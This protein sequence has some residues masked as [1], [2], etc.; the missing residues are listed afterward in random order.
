MSVIRG[1]SYYQIVEGPTWTLAESNAAKHGGHLTSIQ[2][3]TE[4]AFL[5]INFVAKEGDYLTNQGNH[6]WIGAS[7]SGSEGQ[8]RWSDGSQ[9][10]YSNWLP[11][12]PDNALGGENYGSLQYKSDGYWNDARDNY[13]QEQIA[14]S[15]INGI[16]E[17]PL[18]LSITHI[19]TPKEGAEIFTTSINL[20]AGTQ[21]S[22]NLAEGAKVYWKVTGITEDDLHSGALM[23]SGYISNGSLSIQ[24]SLRVDAD[25][26]EKM[27][28]SVFSDAS[29]TQQIGNASSADI[30]ESNSLNQ[31]L[32]IRG[33][34]IYRVVDGPTWRSAEEN[35]TKLGGHLFTVNT[36]AE[37]SWLGNEFSDIKYEYPGDDAPWA[38]NEFSINHFWSGGQLIGG[39]W[40]WVSG[41]TFNDNLSSLYLNNY[42]SDPASDKLLGIFN[43]PN[44][45]S[46][47]Y[48]D[49]SRD[50]YPSNPG[51][52]FKGIAEIP[53][54]LT[55]SQ[56]GS[57]KENAIS[58]TTSINISAGTSVSGNLANGQN[59]FWR[60]SGISADDLSAGE[61]E[62][63]GIITGGKLEITHALKQD[64]DTGE[65]F[66]IS[67]FSDAT[68]RHQIGSDFTKI[69][70]EDQS[71]SI[72]SIANSTTTEGDNAS[73][74]ITRT[75]K[76]S[77]VIILALN[78]TDGTAKR[79]ADYTEIKNQYLTF[80]P[81]ETSKT[82]TIA[83]KEDAAAEGF[84]SFSLEL[85]SSDPLA[86]FTTTAAAITILDDDEQG[87]GKPA[88]GTTTGTT[89]GTGN[90]D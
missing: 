50:T 8:W 6:L 49:D 25:R 67:V 10:A 13:Y 1:N 73:I 74:V 90:G 3:G 4:N 15:K 78:S 33:N 36:E 53:I 28:V 39:K 46:N 81:G 86:Q 75:G 26:G 70:E 16:A 88:D 45:W 63:E 48:L 17:I 38:P 58:F 77:N 30:L 42:K 34:S 20:S 11:G 35:S 24:H 68:R 83:T 7:D 19:G 71:H 51:Q 60:I 32:V 64:T 59:I 66:A 57:V 41:E 47:I 9:W 76:I 79:G 12:Q 37:N 87:G 65:S 5:N 44:H 54:S 29:Y 89:I 23:G 52:P 61:L 84:E 40:Q 18:T 55:F 2:D 80:A 85:S 56:A 62:G 72:F 43:N 22:G 21:S 82:F 27:T 69:I 14:G 31:P